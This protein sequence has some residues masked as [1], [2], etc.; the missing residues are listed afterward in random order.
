MSAKAEKSAVNG[1]ND[2]T[3]DRAPAA[4]NL[5]IGQ[6]VVAREV[7]L[8]AE[9][10]TVNGVLEGD[11]AVANLLVNRTG[12]VRGRISVTKSAEIYGA[13]LERLD[14]KGDL[15]LRAGSTVAGTVS[16]GRL[17]TEQGANITGEIS[18][19]NERA[20]QQPSQPDRKIEVRP[21][22]GAAPA[23]RIDLSVLELMPGPI[24]ARS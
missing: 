24:A 23:N 2:S 5:F 9:S 7:V 21:S 15:I 8:V 6:G 22:N 11:I 19:P 20:A 13:V 16:Y 17:A 12:T 1:V 3:I 14:V 10:V 4:N 18:C